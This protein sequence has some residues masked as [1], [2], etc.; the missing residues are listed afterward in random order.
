VEQGTVLIKF[1]T[2]E[3]HLKQFIS[4]S[5]LC[6]TVHYYRICDDVG[7]GD[8][9]ES[10]FGYW[11]KSL[12]DT[13]PNIK[14]DNRPFD[15][16]KASSILI[17][18]MSEPLDGWVQCWS[19]IGPHNGFEDSIDKLA[20]E[21]GK[22]F[23][24][25]PCSKIEQ[26]VSLISQ[27]NGISI[28][29]GLVGYSNRREEFGIG[30]KTDALAYQREYRFIFGECLKGAI[31]DRTFNTKPLYDLVIP[32]GSLKFVKPS[33]ETIYYSGGRTLRINMAKP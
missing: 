5:I 1:F 9:Y 26:Y 32:A 17:Y 6:R 13:L 12:N 4:G 8:R 3:E 28:T 23:V 27:A 2:E 29:H 7:R 20:K 15:L 14:M 19:L 11:D 18:P 25:L 22:Y 16:S 33:G 10:C 30:V 31:L 21:F 24:L